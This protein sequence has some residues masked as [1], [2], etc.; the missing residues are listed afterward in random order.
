MGTGAPI[1]DDPNAVATE[2]T[3]RQL[4]V[5]VPD[6]THETTATATTTS[7][8][9][10]SAADIQ[11]LRR[12][13]LALLDLTD[14]RDNR[15]NAKTRQALLAATAMD[16]P[17]KRQT[18]AER[19]SPPQPISE[20]VTDP[21]WGAWDEVEARE[22]AELP[23]GWSASEMSEPRR[24]TANPISPTVP[25][26]SPESSASSGRGR[27]RSRKYLPTKSPPAS[28][29]A[30]TSMASPSAAQLKERSPAASPAP[31]TPKEPPAAFRETK[32]AVP[33]SPPKGTSAEENAKKIQR[34]SPPVK[35]FPGEERR[36]SKRSAETPAESSKRQAI[37][38]PPSSS[39]AAAKAAN[40]SAAFL[41]PEGLVLQESKPPAP[42][43][44]SDGFSD[45]EE[46]EVKQEEQEKVEGEEEPGVAKLQQP[47]NRSQTRSSTSEPE[48]QGAD[49]P[50]P[51]EGTPRANITQALRS[52]PG[53]VTNSYMLLDI[54]VVNYT[55]RAR[56]IW[57][58]ALFGTKQHAMGRR[59][60]GVHAVAWLTGGAM[61]VHQLERGERIEGAAC[62]NGTPIEC[63]VVGK[64]D[65]TARTPQIGGTYVRAGFHT[66]IFETEE[67]TEEEEEPDAVQCSVEREERLREAR[68]LGKR[69][70][71][72]EEEVR[73]Y[74]P[75]GRKA[76]LRLIEQEA[77]GSSHWSPRAVPK[78]GCPPLVSKAQVYEQWEQLLEWLAGIDDHC[79][80]PTTLE[81]R[82]EWVKQA[83]ECATVVWPNIFG[84]ELH[85]QLECEVSVVRDKARDIM[86]NRGEESMA[87]K[88]CG[89][90]LD[91]RPT[92]GRPRST[93]SCKGA[94]AQQ[95]DKS[96]GTLPRQS[97]DDPWWGP[98]EQAAA[99]AARAGQPGG[100]S[101]DPWGEKKPEYGYPWQEDWTQGW[102]GAELQASGT[103]AKWNQ[104]AVPTELWTKYAQEEG[105]TGG[106]EQSQPSTAKAQQPHPPPNHPPPRDGRPAAGRTPSATVQPRGSASMVVPP[107]PQGPPPTQRGGSSSSASGG[108]L[109]QPITEE[110]NV[111][112]AEEQGQATERTEE[113]QEEEE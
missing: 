1:S 100:H 41:V 106:T 69:G 62:Y 59:I 3:A 12:K 81:Q 103:P 86:E 32:P 37:A 9:S 30:R 14:T 99:D 43:T 21:G 95:E 70:A 113:Q 8:G 85:L 18:A 7:S 76:R 42:P 75:D 110:P 74:D 26:Q 15:N 58:C 83:L 91:T 17:E 27:D 98:A 33:K 79:Q 57:S 36:D 49:W 67:A 66:Y 60:P 22:Y 16:S 20:S 5:P 88:V 47:S 94:A 53:A 56:K 102:V 23:G 101:Q 72:T 105:A 64:G 10:P 35:P 63:F 82:V 93:R 6:R 68:E 51:P 107:S 84:R 44:P 24:S 112:R 29:G 28:G 39:Q 45:E 31:R 2:G 87:A 77:S 34:R 71:A 54:V 80:D 25:I 11:E 78:A 109:L 46:V 96:R 65:S 19:R 61:V 52:Q 104:E 48:S 108:N 111:C 89:W 73:A 38:S 97:A 92:D 4:W 13:R 55:T 40:R 50:S 90:P